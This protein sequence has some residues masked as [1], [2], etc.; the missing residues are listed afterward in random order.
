METFSALL[1]IC[2]GNS[3][4]PGEFPTQRPVTRSFDVFFDVRP[5]KRLSKQSWGWWFETLSPSLWR[6]RNVLHIFVVLGLLQSKLEQLMASRAQ[7]HNSSCSNISKY[8]IIHINVRIVLS[9]RHLQPSWRHKPIDHAKSAPQHCGQLFFYVESKWVK[10]KTVLFVWYIISLRS[11]QL[12]VRL[13]P[14]GSTVGWLRHWILL[15]RLGGHGPKWFSD[16]RGSIL[17][18]GTM[19]G[20]IL[21]ELLRF[22]RAQYAHPTVRCRW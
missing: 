9:M 10:V 22:Q 1:A 6:H 17:Q 4:V 8:V 19:D 16:I 5:N 3:P 14:S 11:V 18:V 7:T 13:A 15:W 20:V 21:H 12:H 2:A